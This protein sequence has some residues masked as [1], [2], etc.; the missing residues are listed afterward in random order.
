MQSG[1]RHTFKKHFESF[2][3][4]AQSTQNR[5]KCSRPW[6]WCMKNPEL[7]Y[8]CQG[9][10]SGQRVSPPQLPQRSPQRCTPASC[11]NGFPLDIC[12]CIYVYI[13][14]ACICTLPSE[15]IYIYMPIDTYHTC[16]RIYI[17]TYIY[18]CTHTPTHFGSQHAI[19]CRIGCY[20]WHVILNPS[21]ILE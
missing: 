1:F 17:S 18:I 16:I 12:T 11:G 10:A 8:T 4:Q 19:S 14:F 7:R 3:S 13:C 6:I 2:A 5:K 15:H 20:V 21:S 9:T